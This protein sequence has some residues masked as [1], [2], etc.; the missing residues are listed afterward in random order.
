MFHLSNIDSYMVIIV[1]DNWNYQ[2]KLSD[3]EN[4]HTQSRNPLTC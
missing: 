2:L 3:M 1:T 4:F